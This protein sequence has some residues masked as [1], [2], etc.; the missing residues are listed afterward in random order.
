M[1]KVAVIIEPGFE[2]GETLTI[3][4]VLRRAEIK[5]DL[6]GSNEQVIG[7]HNIVVKPDKLIDENISSDYDMIV[8][9]GGRPGADNLRDNKYV[10]KA[11]KE[12]NKKEKWIAAI[13]A[14]PIALEEAGV[15]ENRNFTAYL[16]YQD[17]IKPGNFK[18]DIVVVDKNLITS[19]GPAT[20]YA[21][22]YALVDILGGDSIKVKK[23][24]LYTN[25]FDVKEDKIY[26]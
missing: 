14:A 4:D 3:V 24:M 13:C 1:I 15:L 9:P 10:I 22:S 23:R 18:E 5:T 25:A 8:L 2:E 20:T 17:V 26:G 19:R 16:G 7:G 6:L 21:F 11:I 12:M